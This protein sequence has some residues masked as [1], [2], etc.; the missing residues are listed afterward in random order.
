VKKLNIISIALVFAGTLALSP[1]AQAHASLKRSSPAANATVEAAPK[2]I[3]L[4][5]SEKVEES[6]SAIA[7]KDAA[8]KEVTAAKTH[9]D[10]VDGAT[11]HLDAPLLSSG[12]YT[13]QWVAVAHDGHR[14][15]GE[16]K[17]TVK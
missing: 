12:V 15:T 11:L 2:D 14:R 17:F 4:T 10:A 3:S 8:G 16:F 6:F 1:L 5:F 7:L 9:V 13:V